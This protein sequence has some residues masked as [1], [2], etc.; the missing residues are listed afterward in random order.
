MDER[1]F[2]VKR[3]IEIDEENDMI[4]YVESSLQPIEYTRVLEAW[5]SGFIVQQIDDL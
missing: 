3:V 4:A 1:T 5:A 2:F